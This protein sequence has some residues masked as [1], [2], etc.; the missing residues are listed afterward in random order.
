VDAASPVSAPDNRE[1]EIDL[2]D[3]GGGAPP[4]PLLVAVLVFADGPPPAL[5]AAVDQLLE[6]GADV[7]Y[8]TSELDV[9]AAPGVPLT[10]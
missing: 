10:E 4:S 9:A 3:T 2:P 7:V 8:V 6:F 1:V 5:P